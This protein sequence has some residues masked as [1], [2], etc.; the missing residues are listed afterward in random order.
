MAEKFTRELKTAKYLIEWFM[1]RRCG[2]Q[3]FPPHPDGRR[4]EIIFE[5]C[6]WRNVNQLAAYG[7][8]ARRYPHWQ[9]GMEYE[10]LEKT[11]S[12]G[13]SKI[14]EMVINTDPCIAYLLE[15][16]SIVDQKL[17]MAHVYGHAD[18][19][20]NNLYFADTNRH[21]ANNFPNHGIKVEE[22][23]EK[24]GWDRVEEWLDKAKMLENLIDRHRGIIK[25]Q[26]DGGSDSQ[27][28]ETEEEKEWS[29]KFPAKDYMD[30]FINPEDAVKQS[31]EEQKEKKQKEKDIHERGLVFPSEPERDALWFL[32]ENAPLE[33][34]QREL[35]LIIREEACYYAPQAQTK[36]MNEGWAAHW[37]SVAM[38][39]GIIASDAEIIDYADRNA[40][41][42][43][44]SPGRVNPYALG[45]AIFRD[46]EWR[47]DSYRYGKIWDEC[48]D[49]V[50]QGNWD[51]FVAFKGIW[52]E[53]KNNQKLF[54]ERWNEFLCFMRAIKEGTKKLPKDIYDER[55]ILR[56]WHYYHTLDER[57][58]K[59]EDEISGYIKEIAEWN[60]VVRNN[61]NREEA[62][63]RKYALTR[64]HSLKQFIRFTQRS[65][66]LLIG[67]DG[68]R[69]L[70][71]ARKL[72]SENYTI[73]KNF[74]IYAEKHPEALVIGDGMRKIFEV[75]RNYCDATFIDEFLT[76]EIAE[77]LSLF[78]AAYDKEKKVH[79]IESYEFETVKRNLV[80][81]LTN[82][83][84]PDV[85]IENANFQNKGELLLKHY[86]DGT[87]IDLKW[88]KD[89]LEY[90]LYPS[91]QRPVH[92]EMV[93]N[94]EKIVLS[95]NG[96]EFS[97]A[98]V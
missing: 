36:I 78:S 86:Y 7:G 54:S 23:I 34:W 98:K 22:M 1:I 8:F 21:A 52:E 3:P 88:T 2:L 6:D 39:S 66:R 42:L 51:Y 24:Y 53:A 28:Q 5:V 46:I 96:K 9:F 67:L 43:A 26:S 27:L 71:K 85:R 14:Y 4:N 16:N 94:G 63:Q 79:V 81:Q 74:F 19:F 45:R 20:V 33:N 13:L 44:I 11:S 84:N 40:G 29:G 80:A 69:L 50:V 10:E 30:R 64:I 73:P 90:S 89:V 17:V 61:S 15:G 92:V 41:T 77:E 59:I 55:L 87:E 38:T 37:H 91:W 76:R 49:F 97:S 72:K 95:Y 70:H 83:G 47:W 31:R 18:F 68:I 48:D 35:F 60:E 62:K 56:Y 75:R 65:K 58:N 82:S 25:R 12:Y 57:L 93:F 32:A